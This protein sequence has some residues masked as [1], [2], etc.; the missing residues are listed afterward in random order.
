MPH[1]HKFRPVWL[2]LC[3][4]AWASGFHRI[5]T[6]ARCLVCGEETYLSAWQSPRHRA[7][8]VVGEDTP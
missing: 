1:T 4:P 2:L 3:S 8:P 7:R 5:I 6:H